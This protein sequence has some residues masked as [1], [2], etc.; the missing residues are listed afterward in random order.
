MN[1]KDLI[2]YYNDLYNN[3][4]VP[5]STKTLWLA[6]KPM[7][8]IN[9]WFENEEELEEYINVEIKKRNKYVDALINKEDI[10]EMDF[11]ET[12]LPSITRYDYLG[13]FLGEEN[14][15]MKSNLIYTESG[16]IPNYVSIITKSL[17]NNNLKLLKKLDDNYV[18]HEYIKVNELDEVY[19][20]FSKYDI[21]QKREKVYELK[22]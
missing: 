5:I 12:L 2:N 4:D 3:L 16:F 13:D 7:S 17:P 1:K 11:F 22:K 8:N 19:E 18:W 20:E 21:E 9:N 10:S 6:T 15:I 14:V